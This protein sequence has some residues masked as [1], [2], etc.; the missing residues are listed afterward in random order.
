MG[1]DDNGHETEQKALCAEMKVEFVAAPSDRIS[2][3]ALQTKGKLPLNGLRHPTT[4]GTTGWYLWCGEEISNEKDFYE[5]T[6]TRHIYEEFPKVTRLLG[7]PPGHRFLIA[8][9]YID[10]W[11]DPA[12]LDI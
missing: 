3:V 7:L 10:I 9:E 12:L 1:E 11:F 6:C 4:P 8:G 2:G 5:P